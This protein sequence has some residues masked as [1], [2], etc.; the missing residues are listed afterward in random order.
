MGHIGRFASAE[1]IRFPRGARVVCRT[2]RGL[3]VGE[4][5]AYAC[6]RRGEPD[7]TLLR[8]VTV[9]DELLLARLQ[10]HQQ[11]AFRACQQLLSERGLAAVLV[12]VEHLFDGR[13]LYFY[14]LGEPAA[15]LNELTAELAERYSVAVQFQRFAETL[16]TGCGPDCGTERAGGGKCGDGG[17]AGCAASAACGGRNAG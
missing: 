6:D 12:D 11:Q 10:R 15:E 3:E 9:A 2:S 13:S 4:V 8:Q 5:L 1:W 16:A 17:C 7:G 14:F